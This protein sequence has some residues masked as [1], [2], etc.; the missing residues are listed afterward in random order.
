[1][2]APMLVIRMYTRAYSLFRCDGRECKG[3]GGNMGAWMGLRAAAL[4][5]TVRYQRFS[6]TR[7]SAV[8]TA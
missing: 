4:C 6:A 2:K 8:L 1:M 7:G 3:T 5:A